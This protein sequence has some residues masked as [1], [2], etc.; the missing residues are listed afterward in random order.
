MKCGYTDLH[1]TML[2]KY[3]AKTVGP[4]AR[5]GEH[6]TSATVI[7]QGKNRGGGGVSVKGWRQVLR[8]YITTIK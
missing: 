6:R 7:E 2:K 8:K 1:S 3:I 4:M 5:K